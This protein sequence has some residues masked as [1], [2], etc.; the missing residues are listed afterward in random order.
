MRRKTKRDKKNKR[1]TT[2]HQSASIVATNHQKLKM[3][4]GNQRRIKTLNHQPGNPTE[5]IDG[6]RG[7]R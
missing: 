6:A 4:V 5:A 3:N 2:T 7:P 1:N